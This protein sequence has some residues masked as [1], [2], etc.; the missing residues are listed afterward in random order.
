MAK[1]Q[2]ITG[3]GAGKKQVLPVDWQE[4]IPFALKLER[5]WRQGTP[6][7]PERIRYV[8]LDTGHPD[9]RDPGNLDRPGRI[10][11]NR[12]ARDQSDS[13]LF[14]VIIPDSVDDE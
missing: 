11:Q 5:R 9:P 13:P 14:P 7:L 2:T 3:N 8:E 10:G 12:R 1:V 4:A 6:A